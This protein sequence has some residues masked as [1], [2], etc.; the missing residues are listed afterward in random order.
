MFYTDH[1][2]ISFLQSKARLV[3][4]LA[5]WLDELQSYDYEISYIPGKKN[6]IAN[7]LSR[8]SDH[9]PMPKQ[10]SLKDPQ[11]QQQIQ[12]GYI[13]DEWSHRMIKALGGEA[14]SNVA[15]SRQV[16][17][18]SYDGLFLR[19]NGT[20]K[21]RVYFPRVDTLRE[22]VISHFHDPSNPGMDKIYNSVS[23]YA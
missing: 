9:M 10:A 23:T 8:R 3:G 6:V 11:L 16:M 19:W 13:Q 20:A 22:D 18:F 21:S 2:L 12:E 17:N 4:R 15:V 14:T 7:A 1:E 5:R